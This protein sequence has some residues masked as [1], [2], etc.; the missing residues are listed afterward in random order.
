[1]ETD[2]QTGR[3]TGTETNRKTARKE[4]KEEDRYIEMDRQR[5]GKTKKDR[6]TCQV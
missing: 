3:E 6:Q 4:W 1:M 5:E 2:R